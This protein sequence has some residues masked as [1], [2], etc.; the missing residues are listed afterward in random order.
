MEYTVWILYCLKPRGYPSPRQGTPHET[1][2]LPD[3]NW[4]PPKLGL[5]YAPGLD[6]G[7]PSP[8]TEV[9]PTWD[10]GTPQK[11]TWDQRP[12][13]EH[14]TGVSPSPVNGQT[15]TNITFPYP[16]GMRTVQIQILQIPQNSIRKSSLYTLHFFQPMR[17]IVNGTHSHHSAT[18]T[19]LS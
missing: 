5:G 10:W 3:R 12:V 8:E 4:V 15:C 14:G 16:F 9:Y 19:K 18:E 6:C 11:R 17:N 7:T 2:V 1:G 13:K